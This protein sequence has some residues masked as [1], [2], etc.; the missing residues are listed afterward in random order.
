MSNAK[1][2]NV[3]SN[4]FCEGEKFYYWDIKPMNVLC[5]YTWI[6]PVKEEFNNSKDGHVSSKMAL[7][8]PE[9]KA[10]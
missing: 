1:E 10:F 9:T 7:I 8:S 5:L 2:N 3:K 4:Y 6:T